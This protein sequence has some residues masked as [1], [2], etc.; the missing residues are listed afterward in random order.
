[1]N[2]ELVIHLDE[3]LILEENSEQEIVVRKG[4][5]Y[6]SENEILR[7]IDVRE[8]GIMLIDLETY[9]ISGTDI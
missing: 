2:D 7:V 9:K 3:E 1:M 8:E 6:A 5:I 4:E